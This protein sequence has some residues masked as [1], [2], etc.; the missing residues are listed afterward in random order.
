[1]MTSRIYKPALMRQLF[2]LGCTYSAEMLSLTKMLARLQDAENVTTLS[3]Y[4][5]L[6]DECEL[7][8]YAAEE[9]RKYNSVPKYQVYN[10]SLLT[11]YRGR[12]YVADR[13]DPSVWGRWVESAVGAFMVSA[14]GA[15]DYRVYY[16]RD[17]RDEVDFV[18]SG[19]GRTLAIEVKSGRCGMN[20]GI[21][22]LKLGC[23]MG[24]TIS[25]SN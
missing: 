25:I 18:I 1:M 17:G 4:L 19:H 16:W 21:P 7:Q 24:V 15:G 10:N 22:Y 5:Q 9:S 6:L 13:T 3:G 2:E 23:S 12:S 11:A 8:K 20:S 14:A